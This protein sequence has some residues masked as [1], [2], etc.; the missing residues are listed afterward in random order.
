MPIVAAAI[1]GAASLLGGSSRNSASAREGKR[2]RAF[3]E[4]MSNTAVRRRFADLEAAG[5]NPILAAR[6]DAT[7]PPGAMASFGNVGLEGVQGAAAAANT[8]M[9]AAKTEAEITKLEEEARNLVQDW[10]IKWSQGRILTWETVTAEFEAKIREVGYDQAE[11]ML[12]I[13]QE[14]LKLA[15]RKG[16]I[17]ESEAGK[18]FAWIS[19]AGGAAG[20]LS[21]AI[22]RFRGKMK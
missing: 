20:Q 13:M 17:A 5:V 18:W 21:N 1:G 11:T 4:R 2:N 19:E 8:S 22:P 12:D 6:H 7:T 10:K 9:A 3:Q 15:V 16:E 14:E